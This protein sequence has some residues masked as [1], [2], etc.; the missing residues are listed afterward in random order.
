MNLR[1]LSLDIDGVLHPTD[2]IKNLKISKMAFNPELTIEKLN[3]FRWAN[4][5]E[6]A[7]KIDPEAA[8]IVHSS[9]RHQKWA[10]N[11]FFRKALG[12]LGHRFIACTP[13]DVFEREL[14]INYFCS[15]ID[16]LDCLILDDAYKEFTLGAK[17]P[18]LVV[19]NPLTGVND[20]AV[21]EKIN[22]WAAQKP[23]YDR[24]SFR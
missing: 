7:L 6:D 16:A 8:I 17:T 5:L 11:E 23:P 19:T 12:P 22:A 24:P 18:N 10:T 1:I 4:E 3:L 2:A 20:V 13:T 9:W 21:L 15:R 14:S